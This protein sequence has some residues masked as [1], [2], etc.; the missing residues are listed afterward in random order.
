MAQTKV[1]PVP[2]EPLGSPDVATNQVTV[3]DTATLIRAADPR[4]RG[5]LIVNHGTTAVFVGDSTV[6]TTTGL[7][8]AGVVG[9]SV[10]VPTKG[11][12]YG[13]VASG[14]QVVSYMVVTT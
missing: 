4:R 11:A 14:S 2:I 5:L 12:V 7:L 13:V 9:A 10:S 1:N 3:A 6:T 8:L